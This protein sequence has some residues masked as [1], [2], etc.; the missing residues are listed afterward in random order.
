MN[1]AGSVLWIF[2]ASSKRQIC[3]PVRIAD[4]DGPQVGASQ[5]ACVK[6]SPSRA[7]RSNAGVWTTGSPFAP[8]WA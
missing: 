7:T 1:F 2:P 6:R 8:V 4:R 3:W 5:N